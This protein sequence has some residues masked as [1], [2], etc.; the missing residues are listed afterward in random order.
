MITSFLQFCEI[1]EDLK[2]KPRQKRGFK[3]NSCVRTQMIQIIL[4]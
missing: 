4:V 2:K 3:F 1:I